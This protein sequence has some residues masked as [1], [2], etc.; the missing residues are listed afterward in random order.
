MGITYFG[1]W[2]GDSFWDYML[3]MGC[4]SSR[5]VKVIEYQT[6]DTEENPEAKNEDV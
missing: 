6:V 2:Y 3:T 5:G 4:S 1:I